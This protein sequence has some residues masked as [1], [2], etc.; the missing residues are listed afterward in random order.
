MDVI[1]LERNSLVPSFQVIVAGKNEK[2]W[3][4]I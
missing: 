3:Y 4:V 2:A 1:D